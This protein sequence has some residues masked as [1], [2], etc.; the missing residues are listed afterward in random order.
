M[1]MSK[2]IFSGFDESIKAQILVLTRDPCLINLGW[3]TSVCI[4]QIPEI[5][6]VCSQS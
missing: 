5:K 2:V 3:E 1:E 4:L 6:L